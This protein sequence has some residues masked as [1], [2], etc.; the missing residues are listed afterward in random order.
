MSIDRKKYL[1]YTRDMKR[2][3][4]SPKIRSSHF[5]TESESIF[6]DLVRSLFPTLSTLAISKLAGNSVSGGIVSIAYA[7]YTLRLLWQNRHAEHPTSEVTLQ[8]G[9]DIRK[10]FRF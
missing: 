6:I 7:V 5:E 1:F 9:R 8:I 4:L 2:K 3:Y 10:V